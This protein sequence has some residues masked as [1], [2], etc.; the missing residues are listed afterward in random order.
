MDRSECLVLGLS[1]AGAAAALRL[2]EAGRAVTLVELPNEVPLRARTRVWSTPLSE[3]DRTGADY[4]SLVE[5]T[6]DKAGVRVI[7]DVEAATLAISGEPVLTVRQFE[8]SEELEFAAPRCVY[9]SDGAW[10][11]AG[12]P[13]AGRELIGKGVSASAWVDST[14]YIGKSA[15]VIGA[16]DFAYEQ[17]YWAGQ[18]VSELW[19]LCPE[20]RAMISED[21]MNRED[22][23]VIP[24]LR[25]SVELKPVRREGGMVQCALGSGETIAVHGAFFALP[26]HHDTMRLAGVAGVAELK[27][28]G[29]KVAGAAAGVPWTHHAGAWQSGREAA[30]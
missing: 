29:V 15:A 30:G 18:C 1:V 28:R 2:S 22:L 11:V 12:M 19:W 5:R 16:G 4:E 13:P 20:A 14:F 9:A 10:N 17:L 8:Q 7:R 23:P 25:T 3:R 27:A 24:K 21:L 6:L 26:P